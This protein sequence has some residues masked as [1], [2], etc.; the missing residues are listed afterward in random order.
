MAM[1]TCPLVSGLSQLM[2]SSSSISFIA[3]PAACLATQMSSLILISSLTI[4]G[5]CKVVLNKSKHLIRESKTGKAFSGGGK[6]YYYSRRTPSHATNAGYWK[7]VGTEE[8]IFSSTNNKKIGLKSSFVFHLGQ[9]PQGTSTDW[10]MQEFRL[11]GS[12][13][14]SGSSSSSTRRAQSRLD[15]RRWVLCKVYERRSDDSDDNDGVELSCLDEVFLSMDD[16]DEISL[17]F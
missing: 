12:T 14:S 9:P 2:R 7:P 16:L 6:W 3:R 8:S 17:P 4:L 13:S 1:L 10:T 11:P 5:N 15:Q